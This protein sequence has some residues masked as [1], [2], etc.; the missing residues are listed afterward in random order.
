MKCFRRPVPRM[1]GIIVGSGPV[2]LSAVALTPKEL[3]ISVYFGSAW[4]CR[5]SRLLFVVSV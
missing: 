3:I 1:S 5:C 4:L 2:E